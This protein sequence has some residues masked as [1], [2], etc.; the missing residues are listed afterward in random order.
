MGTYFPPLNLQLDADERA[1]KRAYAAALKD[2]RPED[3]PA[4]FQ[5]LV[6]ARDRALAWVRRRAAS[7]DLP[8]LPELIESLRPSDQAPEPPADDGAPEASAPA[9][10]VAE[11][12]DEGD[13]SE[14]D[15]HR[16]LREILAHIE[17]ASTPAA[18]IPVPAISIDPRDMGAVR[19]SSAARAGL[20][21]D[22]IAL[23]R[24][25][26]A[27]TLPD[28][29]A[30]ARIVTE[31]DELDLA[32]RL[33]L[34]RII[35]LELDAAL[36]AAAPEDADPAARFAPTI[37]LLDHAFRWSDD[38]RRVARILGEPSGSHPLVFAIERFGERAVRLRHSASGFPLVPEADLI[39]W[40]GHA[41]HAGVA[42][43]RRAEARDGFAPGWS[44]YAF[45]SPPAFAVSIGATI[46]GLALTLV[47][48]FCIYFYFDPIANV[49]VADGFACFLALLFAVRA[50]FA[51]AARPVEI[52]RLVRCITRIEAH[53][54]PPL[55][56]RRKRIAQGRGSSLLNIV[57]GLVFLLLVDGYWLSL[58]FPALNLTDRSVAEMIVIPDRKT[59]GVTFADRLTAESYIDHAREIARSVDDLIHDARGPSGNPIML[60]RAEAL[61]QRFVARIKQLP[62]GAFAEDFDRFRI[63]IAA[64][65]R[66]RP[67]VANP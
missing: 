57:C 66:R 45:L 58:V 29:D 62:I 46:T 59:P 53:G 37:V 42:A 13:V 30:W 15:A 24:R 7:P 32:G 14:E 10:D 31:G 35:I 5:A 2:R 36:L 56:V 8:E 22:A 33:S 63:E 4:A 60:A 9:G 11:P 28:Q 49:Y 27:G 17:E 48:I 39:A 23:I 1:V 43:Y 16:V 61:K 52:A 26:A 3:D 54:L 67:A 20:A 34:E 50:G 25:A 38:M 41:G 65:K 44:W 51:L 12:V 55:A 6:E 21:A 64:A 47:A 40:Y 18:P 19:P